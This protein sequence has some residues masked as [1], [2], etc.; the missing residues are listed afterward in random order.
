MTEFLFQVGLLTFGNRA[1]VRWNL[2]T[3]SNVDSLVRAINSDE[4]FPAGM[5]RT[6][7]YDG[8]YRM[9]TELFSPDHGSRPDVP[10]IAIVI[11]DGHATLNKYLTVP[12][13]RRSWE[14][15]IQVIAIPALL[16]LGFLLPRVRG[17]SYGKTCLQYKTKLNIENLYSA[18]I[19]KC[20]GALI[21]LGNIMDCCH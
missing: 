7:L 9:R 4:T 3:Y 2:I 13:A 20:P 10:H 11:T 14:A 6:N 16:T 19:R 5:G 21:T 17:S 1:I 18:V 12:E 15:G 8:L